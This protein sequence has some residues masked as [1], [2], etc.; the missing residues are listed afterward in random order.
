MLAGRVS[1]PRPSARPKL[2]SHVLQWSPINVFG[3]CC[4]VATQ[5][6]RQKQLES[7][8]RA[9]GLQLRRAACWSTAET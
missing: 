4:S 2:D 3:G 1:E 7:V 5:R 9:M 6:H 8:E